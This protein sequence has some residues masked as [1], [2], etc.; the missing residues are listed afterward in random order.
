MRR[1]KLIVSLILIVLITMS[2]GCI[3]SPGEEKTESPVIE[4]AH[5]G[6]DERIS[7]NTSPLEGA[8]AT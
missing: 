3:N 5:E 4:T 6:V 8:K 1:I 7:G 2:N